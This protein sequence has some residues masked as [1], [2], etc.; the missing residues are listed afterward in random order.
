M[1]YF[2][3]YNSNNVLNHICR[4]ENSTNIILVKQNVSKNYFYWAFFFSIVDEE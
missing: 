3:T 4:K 1:M 2:K